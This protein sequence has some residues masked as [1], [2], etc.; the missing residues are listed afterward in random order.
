M[1]LRGLDLLSLALDADLAQ[2]VSF[3]T[4]LANP[5]TDYESKSLGSLHGTILRELQNV[6][7]S[8]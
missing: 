8:S 3:D 2:Y 6:V 4:A 1:G 7:A 5:I